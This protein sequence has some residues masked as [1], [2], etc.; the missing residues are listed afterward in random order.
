MSTRLHALLISL[1]LAWLR[2]YRALISPYLGPACRFE[3]SCSVYAEQALRRHGVRRG[4]WLA[5]RRL[6]R[7][8]PL[9]AGGLDPVP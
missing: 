6:T 3:P 5:A 4:S 2:A 8:H 1:L 9:H 7:C